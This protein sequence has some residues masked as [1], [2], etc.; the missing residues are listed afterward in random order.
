MAL[1]VRPGTSFAISAHLF[2]WIF[3]A[4]FAVL[5]P[6][7]TRFGFHT[8]NPRAQWSALIFVTRLFEVSSRTLFLGC[9]MAGYGP[10]VI[11]MIAA[12]WILIQMPQAFLADEMGAGKTLQAL[13]AAAAV[14]DNHWPVLV[15]EGKGQG[16]CPS[17]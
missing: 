2:P 9:V 14:R 4:S 16:P 12:E 10:L 11:P 6:V 8:E 17:T 13:A 5:D 3:W 7:A 1:S 15:R